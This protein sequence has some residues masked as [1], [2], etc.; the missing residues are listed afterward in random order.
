MQR[1]GGLISPNHSLVSVVYGETV[2]GSRGLHSLE[3][4]LQNGA[5][6]WGNAQ[7]VRSDGRTARFRRQQ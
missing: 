3:A 6:Y 4:A 7:L 2:V 5:P 1:G